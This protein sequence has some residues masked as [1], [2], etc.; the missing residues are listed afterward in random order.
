MGAAGR[1]NLLALYVLDGLAYLVFWA[2]GCR[3]GELVTKPVLMLVLAGYVLTT[4]WAPRSRS[5]GLLVVAGR[6]PEALLSGMI[7]YSVVEYASA[8]SAIALRLSLGI[9][10]TLFAASDAL[11]GLRIAHVTIQGEF[12][13]MVLYAAAQL[14][15]AVMALSAIRV[16]VPSAAGRSRWRPP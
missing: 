3:T 14:L 15:I 2:T 16:H 9:G 1:R 10:A 13:V 6:V 11:I 5:V 4:R 7:V 8:A 12:A